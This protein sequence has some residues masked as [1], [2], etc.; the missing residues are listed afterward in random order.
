MGRLTTTVAVLA[1]AGAFAAL[2]S[3]CGERREPTAATVPISYP[4][5]VQGANE[6]PLELARAPLRVLPV[7]ASAVALV[8]ALGRRSL[9][10]GAPATGRLRAFPA[11]AIAKTPADLVV[12]SQTNDANALQAAAGAANTPL[13]I[14]ADS[15][16]LDL[17]HSILE[18]G[19]AIGAPVQ[20]RTLVAAIEARRAKVRAKLKGVA[21]VTVFVDTG[22]F[23]PIADDTF[24][25]EL[26]REAGV[27]NSAGNADATPFPIKDLLAAEPAFYLATEA[28]GTTLEQLRKTRRVRNLA[29]IRE[30]RF[31]IIPLSLLQPGP[32]VGDAIDQLYTILHPAP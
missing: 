22:Y 20:A 11:R 25:G 15:S 28:S 6:Q 5:T 3:G 31:A 4:V 1:C 10:P 13:L 2:A 23:I 32:A 24:A 21:P 9:V 19:L 12:G 27:E 30:G 7:S 17:E 18:L 26:L 29:A 14:L 8:D 16:I